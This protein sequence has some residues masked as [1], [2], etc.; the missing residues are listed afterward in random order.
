LI[1]RMK[2]GKSITVKDVMDLIK[3]AMVDDEYAWAWHCN[4]A[5]MAYDAGSDHK[6]A[7]EGAAR[8]MSLAFDKDITQ[9]PEY[10]DIMKG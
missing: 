6:V 4:I 9:F 1:V 3:M 7:N 10:K 2:D 5:M 8:F